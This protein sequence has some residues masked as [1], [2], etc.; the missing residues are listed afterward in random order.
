MASNLT[1]TA[2]GAALGA[3]ESLLNATGL[4]SLLNDNQEQQPSAGDLSTSGE[5]TKGS[6][7]S[8]STAAYIHQSGES[9]HRS[10]LCPLEGSGR[11]FRSARGDEAVDEAV[12]GPGEEAGSG[13]R[14]HTPDYRDGDTCTATIN[15]LQL[16]HS[17]GAAENALP[18]HSNNNNNNN[19]NNNNSSS[20]NSS[21]S[22]SSSI[23]ERSSG[24]SARRPA[25]RCVS[26]DAEYL[27]LEDDDVEMARSARVPD[28]ADGHATVNP[29][30][31]QGT[32][33]P[34]SRALS[35][36]AASAFNEVDEED[37][38]VFS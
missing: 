32:G 27:K 24:S 30:L 31:S 4:T 12:D 13:A 29:M 7:K 10:S 6:T 11:E 36:A 15:P 8:N 19:H 23:S 3:G 25:S 5:G 14:R 33:G 35:V 37:D 16:A 28:V 1:G 9:I 2:F 18:N 34:H 22:S 26:R 38:D 20:S 21:S 17:V